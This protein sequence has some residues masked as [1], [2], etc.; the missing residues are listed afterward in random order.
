MGAGAAEEPTRHAPGR[1]TRT[2]A[3]K[4][5]APTLYQRELGTLL[6]SLRAE[7]GLTVEEVAE[8]LICSPSR[9]RALEAAVDPPTAQDL[10]DLRALFKVDDTTRDQLMDLAQKAQQ[11]GWWAKYEDLGLPYIGL[12]QHASS[13]TSYTM[14]Y[15]PALLQ[16][17]EY[18]RA[19]IEGIAPKMSA[20]IL[21][22]RIDARLRRQHILNAKNLLRYQV[23]LD[24]AVLQRPVGG[25][26]VM[27]AQ[28]DKALTLIR[29]GKATVRIVPFD[30]GAHAALD[31]NFVLLDFEEPG[32]APVV[33]VEGLTTH[34]NLV[35]RK[36]DIDRYREAIDSLQK[37]A[38]SAEESMRLV[39]QARRSY[40]SG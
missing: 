33:Y 11:Q 17:R 40:R 34:R 9:I 16:T 36:E 7:R 18:A 2:T 25:H 35:E 14:W 37:A 39:A 26:A 15:F 23:L 30:T 38:L 27:R 29:E 24:E 28:L 12:E 31:S 13:I 8:T 4:Q 3:S 20:R 19:I 10:D 21:E 22:Q 6:S 32:P 1:L 5:T